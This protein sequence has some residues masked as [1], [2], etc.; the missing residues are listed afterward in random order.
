MTNHNSP[1]AVSNPLQSRIIDLISWRLNLPA[2]NIHPYSRLREDLH[3]DAIDLI[4]LIAELESR[5]NIYLSK[6]EV[7]AIETVQDA[8][9]YLYKAA[10]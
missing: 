8:S 9:F 4:L 10:A 3:L 2:T 1:F 7:E 5:F 6:E